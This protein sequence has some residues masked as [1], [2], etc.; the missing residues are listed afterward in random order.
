[1]RTTATSHRWM[2]RGRKS[3]ELGASFSGWD[4]SCG[5][6]V[7][8]KTLPHYLCEKVSHDSG[9]PEERPLCNQVTRCSEDPCVKVSGLT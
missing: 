1:M 8:M 9:S 7:V 3:P 6:G 5:S 4:G 2:R